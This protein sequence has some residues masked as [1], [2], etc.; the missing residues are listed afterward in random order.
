MSGV[1]RFP[2]KESMDAWL[3]SVLGMTSDEIGEGADDTYPIRW[4]YIT[5]PRVF[6]GFRDP[7]AVQRCRRTVEWGAA[8]IPEAEMCDFLGPNPKALW[9]ERELIRLGL[10]RR[11]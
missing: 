4:E 11:E 9:V 1:L 10:I 7:G 5:D 8:L 6:C 2:S 3:V